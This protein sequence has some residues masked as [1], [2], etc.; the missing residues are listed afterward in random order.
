LRLN[1]SEKRFGISVNGIFVVIVRG[2]FIS[3]F[4]EL[5]INDLKFDGINLSF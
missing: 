1:E 3:I 2:G 4:N 5:I